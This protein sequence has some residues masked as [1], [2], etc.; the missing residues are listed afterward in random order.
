MNKIRKNFCNTKGFNFI[1][2]ENIEEAE[3]YILYLED[4][5]LSKDKINLKKEIKK[6]IECNNGEGSY[7]SYVGSLLE[8]DIIS[9]IKNKLL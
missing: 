5:I 4:L 9:F 3:I 8:S 6:Y 2:F 7:D 1:D